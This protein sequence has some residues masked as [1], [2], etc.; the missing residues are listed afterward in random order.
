VEEFFDFHRGGVGMLA[1]DAFAGDVAGQFMQVQRDGEALFAGHR[2]VTFDL[3]DECL[4]RIHGVTVAEW[5]GCINIV[6][7]RGTS[8]R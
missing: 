5:R 4:L 8:I 7:W 2:A 6:V 3:G 1:A